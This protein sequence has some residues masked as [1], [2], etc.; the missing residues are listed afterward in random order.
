M[1][2]LKPVIVVTL[3]LWIL[4]GLAYPIVTSAISGVLFPEQ[5]AASPVNVGGKVVAA[6]NV[7]QYFD[8]PQYFWGRPSATVSTTTGKPDPYNA[9]NSAPSNLG[10]TNPALLAHIKARVK[11]L[12]AA[13][14]GLK[15]SQIPLDLVESSGSGLDPNISPQAA[16][17][18]I[19]RVAKATGLS[20]ATLRRFVADATTGPQ[21]GL[22]GATV[23]NVV[24]L[25][26]EV[27]KATHA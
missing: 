1:Q 22:F 10:P 11:T 5:A 2:M 3:G 15:T 18:Q 19:P 6:A 8:Q 16:K 4:L 9:Y 14:P 26:L 27:Y 23:V 21:F 17:I 12:Q 24:R 25:N 20:T 7:G 13:N